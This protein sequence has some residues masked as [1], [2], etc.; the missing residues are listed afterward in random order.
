M[1]SNI[2]FNYTII[3]S[4]DQIAALSYYPLLFQIMIL[5]PLIVLIITLL[6]RI[7]NRTKT[8]I[9]FIN[10]IYS[11]LLPVI[12][13]S[14]IENFQLKSYIYEI[15]LNGNLANIFQNLGLSMAEIY[16]IIGFIAFGYT[17]I[18]AVIIGYYD[19]LEISKLIFKIIDYAKSSISSTF[20]SLISYIISRIK[21]CTT[22]N[23]NNK[24]K[25]Y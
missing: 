23:R 24:N 5:I 18:N 12:G 4:V 21:S 10:L 15:M 6:L 11:L 9:L 7:S 19:W 14:I 1:I 16:S 13:I 17:A 3:S 2:S 8:I 20:K 25:K 22:S